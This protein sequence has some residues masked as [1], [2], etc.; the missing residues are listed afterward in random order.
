MFNKFINSLV[1]APNQHPS[2]QCRWCKDMIGAVAHAPIPV[3][4]ACYRLAVT[5]CTPGSKKGNLWEKLTD[6]FESEVRTMV[7]RQAK[8]VVT[9][10]EVLQVGNDCQIEILEADRK[11]IQLLLAGKTEEAAHFQA[12]AKALRLMMTNRASELRKSIVE[13]DRVD[14]VQ[15]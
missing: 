7:R 13:L 3:C 5:H 9:E 1:G 8:L 10:I 4:A 14:A 2:S 12:K 6:Q 11:A 15:R